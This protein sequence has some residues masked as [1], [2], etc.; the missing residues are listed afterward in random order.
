[1]RI[2]AQVRQERLFAPQDSEAFEDMIRYTNT[3]GS[4]QVRTSSLIFTTKKKGGNVLTASVL[5]EAQRLDSL[6]SEHVYASSGLNDAGNGK[7]SFG[8]T[9]SRRDLCHP[10]AS[11]PDCLMLNNPLELFYYANGTYDFETYSDA[12]IAEIVQRGYGPARVES[13]ARHASARV[14]PC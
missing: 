8:R 4:A 3:F 6:V 11:Q 10:R 13:T 12:E 1:M 5:R 7:N 2:A 14:A 9:Y